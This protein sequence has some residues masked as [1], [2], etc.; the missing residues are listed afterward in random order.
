MGVDYHC[1]TMGSFA[2]EPVVSAA[3]GTLSAPGCVAQERKIRS[4]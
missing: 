1:E 4:T 2:L 3:T